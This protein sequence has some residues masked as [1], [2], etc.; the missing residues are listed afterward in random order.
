MVLGNSQTSSI[1]VSQEWTLL[2]ILIFSTA[3]KKTKKNDK[4]ATKLLGIAINEDKISLSTEAANKIWYLPIR[5][6]LQIRQRSKNIV[7][8]CNEQAAKPTKKVILEELIWIQARKRTFDDRTLAT[9]FLKFLSKVNEEIHQRCYGIYETPLPFKQ[10]SITLPNNKE[11]ALNCVNKL[12]KK[13]KADYLAFLSNT[14]SGGNTKNFSDKEVSKENRQVRCI[15]HTNPYAIQ[16]PGK[17][18]VVFQCRVEFQAK[19][20]SHKAQ[21]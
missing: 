17:I 6:I 9:G 5:S 7:E 11:D 12:E 3:Q 21:I 2:S 20:T 14:I 4:E 8:S 19:D 13:A 15:P 16:K 18:R 10:E 1:V